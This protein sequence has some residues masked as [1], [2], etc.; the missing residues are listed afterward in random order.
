M[1]I[2]DYTIDAHTHRFGLWTAARAA[3]TSRF[4]NSE[5]AGFIE[6]CQLKNSLEELRN[7]QNIDYEKY[8]SWFI[9]QVNSIKAC[10]KNYENDNRRKKAFGIAAKIVSIY[11]KTVEI[12]IKSWYG[13]RT[14]SSALS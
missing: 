9:A 7:A 12:N 13:D 8:R 10:I 4:S 6:D 11:V 5:V 3:S 14:R 2:T 1:N